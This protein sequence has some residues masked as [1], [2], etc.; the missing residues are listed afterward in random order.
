VTAAVGSSYLG[1][2]AAGVLLRSAW[3]VWLSAVVVLPEGA[4]GGAAYLVVDVA[5]VLL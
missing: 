2:D 5:G 1:V 3:V 4:T